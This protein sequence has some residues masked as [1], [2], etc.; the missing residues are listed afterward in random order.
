MNTM[1]HTVT[2]GSYLTMQKK[3]LLVVIAALMMLGAMAQTSIAPD[4]ADV[5]S[6]LNIPRYSSLSNATAAGSR[7]GNYVYVYSGADTGT[8]VR[9]FDNSRWLKVSGFSSGGA[10]VDTGRGNTQIATGFH[11]N[12]V[13][14]SAALLANA[15]WSLTGN[16]G[17]TAGTN[18]IGTT[19]NQNFSVKRNNEEQL[20]FGN[21]NIVIGTSSA[22]TWTSRLAASQNSWIGLAY[23][24]GLFVALSGGTNTMTSSDGITWTAR[25]CPSNFWVSIT[26]GNG[27]FVA[28]SYSASN[29][30]MTSPDGI[31]WTVRSISLTDLGWNRV[32][33]GNGLFVAISDAGTNQIMTSPDGINWTARTVP[34]ANQWYGIT[35]G[36]GVFVCVAQTG[37]NQ[38]MTSA[39]GITWTGRTASFESGW[40]EIAFGNGFFVAVSGYGTEIMTSPDGITW[41]TRTIPESFAWS[42]ITFGNGLFVGVS[43]SGANQIMTSPD[44]INWT[45]MNS[46]QSNYW[47]IVRYAPGI[48]VSLSSNGT[49]RVMTSAFN[50]TKLGIGVA[51]PTAAVDFRASTTTSAIMRLRVGLPPTSPN[52]GDV[53]LESNTN[54]GLK[55]RINGVTKTISVL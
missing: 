46:P 9:H 6:I 54:T 1:K 36:N 3:I 20:L 5:R 38:V 35:Y 52:D 42:S 55:I 40:Y 45:A 10:A 29:Q 47:G 13:K 11:I 17:T 18:F 8:Y 21:G 2:H 14:D 44:G 30:V 31:N 49:H 39:D 48:F 34:E 27:L 43:Q 41:T 50:S 25:T 37:T 24:N 26:Y 16:A 23:G 51:T 33:F 19:D 22:L 12:K 7:A 53:W 28:V 4:R 32:T 15:R